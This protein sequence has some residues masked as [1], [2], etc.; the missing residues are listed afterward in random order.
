MSSD[1]AR[2]DPAEK[3]K[4]V[5]VPP[6]PQRKDFHSSLVDLKLGEKF[7]RDDVVESKSLGDVQM[8]ETDDKELLH[9]G[10]HDSLCVRRIK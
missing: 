10:K 1:H 9:S 5:V 2:K 8:M 3:V 4:E 7:E 6:A